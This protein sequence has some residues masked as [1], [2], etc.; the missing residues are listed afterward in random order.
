QAQRQGGQ[1]PAEETQD[2]RHEQR[3][4]DGAQRRLADVLIPLQEKFGK[5]DN[6][7]SGWPEVWGRDR[8]TAA[9]VQGVQPGGAPDGWAE[10]LWAGCFTNSKRVAEHD[11]IF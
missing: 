1:Q 10:L 5:F 7:R 3:R 9:K 11:P 4:G 8:Q 2:Q 6:G